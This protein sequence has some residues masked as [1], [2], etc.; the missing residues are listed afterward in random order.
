[1]WRRR[2]SGRRWRTGQVHLDQTSL[3]I[4]AN[5]LVTVHRDVS[6]ELGTVGNRWAMNV[7]HNWCRPAW[8]LGLRGA[9]PDRGRLLLVLESISAPS[10]ILMG[11]KL[12]ASVYGMNFAYM[13]ELG[14]RFGYPMA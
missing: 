2:V 6:P 7:R 3:F 4:G 9:R 5:Y 10:I 11:M 13:P 8:P 12:V 14:W 1:M